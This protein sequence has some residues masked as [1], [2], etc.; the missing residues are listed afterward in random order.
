MHDVRAEDVLE[1]LKANIEI[2]KNQ[3]VESKRVMEKW[4]NSGRKLVKFVVG[5]EV[6]IKTKNMSVEVVKHSETKKFNGKFVG[7]VK[8]VEIVDA[9]RDIYRLNLGKLKTKMHDVFHVS[10]LKSYVKYKF[11]DFPGRA[12]SKAVVAVGQGSNVYEV[13]RIERNKLKYGKMVYLIFWK[14]YKST[15]VE[16]RT[17]EIEENVGKVWLLDF[18]KND[19]VQLA[20]SRAISTWS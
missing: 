8:I 13:E 10:L 7:P 19:P 5:Q 18:W 11:G 14:G 1:R 9:E 3:L 12:R 20:R 4:Y 15:D 16:A 17:W 6:L 2:C